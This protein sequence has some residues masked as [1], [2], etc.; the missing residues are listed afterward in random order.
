MD[1]IDVQW[2]KISPLLVP[3]RCPDA[4]NRPWC[5]VR[6]VLN[7]IHWVLP[8]GTSWHN[9]PDRCMPLHQTYDRRFQQ[10]QCEG[11][12]MRLLHMVAEDLRL[13]GKPDLSET[14]IDTSFS[15]AQV[16][17]AALRPTRHGKAS[18]II[19]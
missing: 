9:L 8:T 12:V 17:G 7:G 19:M 13:C 11:K 10:W 1:P 2:E 4:R 5:D 6:T 14:S 16:K 3:K 18:K 15:S